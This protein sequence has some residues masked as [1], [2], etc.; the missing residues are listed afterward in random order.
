VIAYEVAQ[1]TEPGNFGPL[2]IASD[3]VRSFLTMGQQGEL[4][5]LFFGEALQGVFENPRTLSIDE[6]IKRT[7]IGD[8]A[9]VSTRSPDWANMIEFLKT[10]VFD[11]VRRWPCEV[12]V[13]QYLPLD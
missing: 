2:S 8:N 7:V 9:P 3:L 11:H 4:D 5:E 10:K 6:R 13:A 1:Q 12:N